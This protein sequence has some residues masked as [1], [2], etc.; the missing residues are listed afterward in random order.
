MVGYLVS[1]TAGI[2]TL[3][4]VVASEI[5][6]VEV[7]ALAMTANAVFLAVTGICVTK[8]Y[9]IITDTYGIHISYYIFAAL[10]TASI[11]FVYFLVPETKKRS[12]SQIQDELQGVSKPML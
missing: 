7:K 8:F 5:F 3:P 1:F 4:M 6:P 11:V 12:L 9:Q 2:G 10:S